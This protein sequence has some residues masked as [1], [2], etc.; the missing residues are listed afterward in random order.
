MVV[1]QYKQFY[2][3]RKYFNGITK[4]YLR[5]SCLRVH[6]GLLVSILLCLLIHVSFSLIV[7]L[8]S[9][10][11]VL[12]NVTNCI[13]HH[14]SISIHGHGIWLDDYLNFK[15][16]KGFFCWKI[17]KITFLFSEVH[18]TKEITIHYAEGDKCGYNRKYTYCG[19]ICRT[20]CRTYKQLCAYEC[21]RGC[22]CAPGHAESSYFGICVPGYAPLCAFDRF[23][24]W[25]QLENELLQFINILLSLEIKCWKAIEAFN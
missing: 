22:L 15:I 20:T 12:H 6:L 19:N 11:F 3:H 4:A 16:L 18:K 1:V 23:W 7:L 5:H 14:C 10:T 2:L 25:N 24:K 17:D 9:S 21:T 8:I 13:F